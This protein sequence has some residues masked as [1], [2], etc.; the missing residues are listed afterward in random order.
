MQ[1]TLD[2][3]DDLAF[4]LGAVQNK[5]PEILKLGLRELNASPG[6]G[7]SGIADILE[8]LAELPTPDEI[9]ALRPTPE[10]QTQISEL[11]EKNRSNGLDADEERLWQSYEYLEHIVRMAKAKAY[12]K[13]QSSQV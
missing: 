1:I 7:F 2:L 3:P 6:E 9:L 5:L 8:F 12:I 10:L 4:Q 13:L 11:L